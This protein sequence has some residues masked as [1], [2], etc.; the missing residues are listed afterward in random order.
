VENKQTSCE[1]T[2]NDFP[3]DHMIE[4]KGLRCLLRE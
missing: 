4:I 3:V 1:D 2:G